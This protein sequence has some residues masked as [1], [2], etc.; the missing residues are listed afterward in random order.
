MYNHIPERFIHLVTR[1]CYKTT[2][3]NSFNNQRL[4]PLTIFDNWHTRSKN[5]RW[6]SRRS[7]TSIRQ[8]NRPHDKIIL[9]KGVTDST[10]EFA[11][12]L[13]LC[14]VVSRLQSNDVGLPGLLF[15][16]VL[17]FFSAFFP[18]R[19]TNPKSANAFDTKRNKRGIAKNKNEI[20]PLSCNACCA[21]N[22]GER[23]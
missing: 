22:S 13:G 9:R 7:W 19:P 16:D 17:N 3:Q 21:S 14:L 4:I 1:L 23:Q 11:S 2:L 15:R 6:S 8:G 12:F 20:S 18:I 10:W 5:F